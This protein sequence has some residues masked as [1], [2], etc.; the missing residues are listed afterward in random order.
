MFSGYDVKKECICDVVDEG[1]VDSFAVVRTYLSDAV[2]LSGMLLT[3][4][5][6]VV[7]DKNYEPL[8]LKHFLNQLK[9]FVER[10]KIK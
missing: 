4:E 10:M 1:I 7:K 5:T 9:L 8:S 3:T 2:S 6:L